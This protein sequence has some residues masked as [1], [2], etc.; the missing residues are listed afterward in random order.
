M[1]LTTENCCYPFRFWEKLLD[2]FLEKFAVYLKVPNIWRT[3]NK[4]FNCHMQYGVYWWYL[5][6]L[7]LFKKIIYR[8]ICRELHQWAEASYY[9]RMNVL[10]IV[11]FVGCTVKSIAWLISEVW[12]LQSVIIVSMMQT[13]RHGLS[14]RHLLSNALHIQRWRSGTFLREALK[15]LKKMYAH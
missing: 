8:W 3:S 1:L 6:P 7:F 15:I 10:S 5:I 4:A 13:D 9:R 2:I 12:L 11:A 14:N